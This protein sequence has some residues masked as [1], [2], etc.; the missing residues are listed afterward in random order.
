MILSGLVLLIQLKHK[1][2][3]LKYEAP[4]NPICQIALY[5]AI[6]AGAT[7]KKPTSLTDRPKELK[8]FIDSIERNKLSVPTAIRPAEP[9]NCS[10]FLSLESGKNIVPS[11][12]D[13]NKEVAKATAA[14]F[15]NIF[16]Y[17]QK[18]P[19]A[20]LELLYRV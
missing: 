6:F 8:Y 9:N 1:Q 4:A 16:F 15:F 19:L 12:L 10:T 17:L 14:I 7:S 5:K 11:K 3:A 13:I 18:L 2:H 20:G